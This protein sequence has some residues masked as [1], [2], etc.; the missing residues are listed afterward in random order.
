V[1]ESSSTDHLV[2]GALDV[3]PI[4]SM[5]NPE[6]RALAVRAR[7]FLEAQPWCVKVLDLTCAFTAAG[8][9][10]VFQADLAPTGNGDPMVWTVV[11]DLPP[12][13]LPFSPA[14]TWK[15]ALASYVFE[16]RRWVAAAEAGQ[17]VD[18]LIPVNAPANREFGAM[19][20]ARLDVI[21]HQLL[22]D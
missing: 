14:D 3:P 17:P 7:E 19:L 5:T 20:A 4:D 6:V 18:H 22:R 1:V 11:G 21:E 8:A 15:D 10:A 12:A 9:I 2:P 16:M 13:Y